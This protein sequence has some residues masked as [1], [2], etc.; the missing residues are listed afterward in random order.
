MKADHPYELVFR[1]PHDDPGLIP[2]L[3][4]GISFENLHGDHGLASLVEFGF[5]DIHSIPYSYTAA[6]GIDISFLPFMDVLIE[7]S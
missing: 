3:A 5:K 6:Y 2:G 7:K 1:T 4:L